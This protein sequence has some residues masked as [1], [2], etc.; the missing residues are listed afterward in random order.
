MQ[1]FRKDQC[2][3]R[4]YK[5]SAMQVKRKW[6]VG[7]VLP[8]PRIQIVS[9]SYSGNDLA[10]AEWWGDYQQVISTDKLGTSWAQ[11]GHK[12]EH[13]TAVMEDDCIN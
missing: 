4:I 11:A 9:E 2:H 5:G 7:R 3:S 13:K 10:E 6:L 12:L 1:V 8:P